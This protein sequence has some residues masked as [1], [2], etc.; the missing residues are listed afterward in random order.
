MAPVHIECLKGKGDTQ[1][2]AEIK[3]SSAKHLLCA[4]ELI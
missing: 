1:L 3:I 4:T 2:Q